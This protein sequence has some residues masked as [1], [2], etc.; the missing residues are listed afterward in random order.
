MYILTIHVCKINTLLINTHIF[1]SFQLIY[2]KFCS[3]KTGF[4]CEI[5]NMQFT[6]TI[7]NYICCTMQF[8]KSVNVWNSY[9]AIIL[10]ALYH[11]PV[12]CS[13]FNTGLFHLVS[14]INHL[15]NFSDILFDKNYYFDIIFVFIQPMYSTPHFQNGWFYCEKDYQWLQLRN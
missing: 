8:C 4:V 2:P 3:L 14:Y 12:H 11:R 7:I 5:C 15:I 13:H 9:N 6:F 1:I 10:Q